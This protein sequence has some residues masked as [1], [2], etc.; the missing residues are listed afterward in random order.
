MRRRVAAITGGSSGVGLSLAR[1]ISKHDYTVALLAR[2]V[3]RVEAAAAALRREGAKVVELPC[4]VGDFAAITDALERLAREYDFRVL[5]NAAGVGRFG[6]VERITGDTVADVF[7]GNLTGL[8]FAS[9][10]A[11]RIFRENGD[12][13]IVSILS[14]A[15][16]VGREQEAAYCASKWGARGFME[17]LRAAVKGSPIRTLTVYPGGMDTP[18]WSTECGLSPDTTKF[19]SPEDVAS[20]VVATMF[21]PSSAFVTELTISRG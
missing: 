3:D 10:I 7:R 1:H 17:A 2:T 19:M 11:L 13:L 18:F 12:G 15:A 14:T 9:S 6:S 20:R 16:L 21:P 4:D 5:V 8:I